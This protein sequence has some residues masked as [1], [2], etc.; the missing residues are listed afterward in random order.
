MTAGPH[1]PGLVLSTAADVN[2]S[3]STGTADGPLGADPDLPNCGVQ[4]A[5]GV[6][7][8]TFQQLCEVE[9]RLSVRP[10]HSPAVAGACLASSLVSLTAHRPLAASGH[11][12]HVVSTCFPL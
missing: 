2:I 5:A 12:S 8:E 3:N 6:H 10:S 1:W 11:S 9:V 7:L 4:R